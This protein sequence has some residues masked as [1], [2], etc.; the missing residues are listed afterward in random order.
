M[1]AI[2]AIILI[3]VLYI[4]RK[5]A[6][7]QQIAAAVGSTQNNQMSWQNSQFGS[8]SYPTNNGPIA[9][10]PPWPSASSSPPQQLQISPYA[11]LLQQSEGGSS[12]LTSEP[13]KLTPDDPNLESIKQQVQMGL[14]ATSANHRDD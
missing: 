1:F 11:H 8:T 12:V 6:R 3:I 2:L 14:F 9:V 4:R 10:S 7:S 5:K 13:S